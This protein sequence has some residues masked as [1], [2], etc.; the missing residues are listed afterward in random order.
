MYLLFEV[1]SK[2]EIEFSG[3]LFITFRFFEL[4]WMQLKISAML[5]RHSY[6]IDSN[7]VIFVKKISQYK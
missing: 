1:F 4:N 6:H 3:L 2:I 5:K 7:D